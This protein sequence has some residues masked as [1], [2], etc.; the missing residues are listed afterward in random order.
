MT[1]FEFV[2][3]VY[4]SEISI[5]DECHRRSSQFVRATDVHH[6]LWGPGWSIF[7]IFQSC[8]GFMSLNSNIKLWIIIVRSSISTSAVTEPPK[9]HW[10]APILLLV[11]LASRVPQEFRCINLN[12][13]PMLGCARSISNL[14]RIESQLLMMWSWIQ[15]E[16]ISR[17]GCQKQAWLEHWQSSVMQEKQFHE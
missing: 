4:V 14:R 15:F 10:F 13:V 6:N 5:C 1:L 16:I 11:I 9:C 7:L 17:L 12:G 3:L 2:D 8:C